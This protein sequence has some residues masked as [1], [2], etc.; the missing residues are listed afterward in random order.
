MKASKKSH[1]D[2]GKSSKT[3]F[4]SVNKA[5]D[6]RIFFNQRKIKDCITVRSRLWVSPKSVLPVVSF[7][8]KKN[9]SSSVGTCTTLS[10]LIFE[11]LFS[12]LNWLM[13]ATPF[14]TSLSFVCRVLTSLGSFSKKSSLRIS[15]SSSSSSLSL[16]INFP[17]KNGS[18]LSSF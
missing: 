11:K 8:G 9:V 13:F 17:N 3:F 5:K 14:V 12:I 16:A 1:Y 2:G 10:S 6:K 15:I 4:E 18:S 7:S